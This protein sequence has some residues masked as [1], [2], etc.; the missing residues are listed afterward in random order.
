M[1]CKM[2]G[3]ILFIGL[4]YLSLGNLLC[5]QIPLQTFITAGGATGSGTTPS[6]FASIGQPFVYDR[7]VSTNNGG[8]VMNANELMFTTSTVVATLPTAQPTTLIFSNVTTTS[9]TGSFTAATGSP[10][11]YIVIR[12]AGSAPVSVPAIGV[13]YKPGDT[14]G[15]ATVVSVGTT[16]TFNDTGLSTGTTYYYEV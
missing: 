13:S 15:D 12:K 3:F 7:P 1:P 4:L 9:L 11:G 5:Q 2:K 16:T 10:A 6:Y 8:G 14:M